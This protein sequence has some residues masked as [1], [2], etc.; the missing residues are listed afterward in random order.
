VRV[1]L[2]GDS[3]FLLY[4]PIIGREEMSPRRYIKGLGKPI[5]DRFDP[6]LEMGGFLMAFKRR[7]IPVDLVEMQ[8]MG[9]IGV[10]NYVE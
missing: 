5:L 8:S 6:T 10:L 3:L 9:I 4:P 1:P 7:R 2:P